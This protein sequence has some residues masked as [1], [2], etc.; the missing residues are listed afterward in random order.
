MSTLLLFQQVVKCLMECNA[1][2]NIKDIHGNTPLIYACMSGHQEIAAFLLQVREHQIQHHAKSL[3]KSCAGVC[4]GRGTLAARVAFLMQC[5]SASR[6]PAAKPFIVSTHCGHFLSLFVCFYLQYGA[7]VN[8]SNNQGN[9]SL[10]EAVIGKHEALVDLLLQY[11]ASVHL[12]NSMQ[13]TPVCYAEPV[14]GP[15]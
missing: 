11:G 5:S 12:R 10:H 1:K 8:L 13:R 9:T 6:K 14:R 2:P 7:S 3:R 4:M 15:G